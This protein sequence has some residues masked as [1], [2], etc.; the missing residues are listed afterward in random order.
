[1]LLMTILCLISGID[2]TYDV[3]HG[4]G[5]HQSGK[6]HRTWGRGGKCPAWENMH[7]RAQQEGAPETGARENATAEKME[8]ESSSNKDEKSSSKAP[9]EE[10]VSKVMKVK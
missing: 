9:A 7:H 8:T 1:M 6:C 2:V 5:R 10:K 4:D 3:H